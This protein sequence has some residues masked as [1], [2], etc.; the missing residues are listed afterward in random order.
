MVLVEIPAGEFKMG[1]TKDTD[2]LALDEEVP[3]HTVYLDTYWIDRTEVTNRQYAKC[4]EAG[5]CTKPANNYSS[6]RG[7]Y[8]D[9]PQFAD[10]PVIFVSWNQAADYCAWAER[11]LP[12]EAEWENAARGPAGH[13][14]PWGDTFDGTL[15]N[16][17]DIN[18]QAAWRDTRFDDGFA[19]TSPVEDY[20]D[21]ASMYGILNMAGN[22]YEWVADWYEPYSQDSLTNPTGPASG[23]DKIIRGGSWG[24]DQTHIRS[25]IR[26]PIIPDNWMDF[27]GFRC[28]R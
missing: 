8:Y 13:I 3:Q 24:D 18:C 16:Y 7:S 15:A 21:G 20:L 12:T 11:R 19:D 22:V 6:N 17:C 14:Y 1:S 27:I 2:P 4:V 5:A 23:I 10:Y 28:A 26:S 25:A 9:N